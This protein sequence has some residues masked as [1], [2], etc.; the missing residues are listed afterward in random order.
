MKNIND[1]INYLAEKKIIIMCGHY[2]AGKTNLSVNF[3]VKLKEQTGF[4]Y[5]LADLDMVNP[6][7]RGAD[8]IGDLREHGI[9]III[10]QFANTNLEVS[11]VPRE[12]HSVFD[13]KE[14]RAIIDIGGDD[15]GAVILGVLTDKIQRENYELIY[16]INK[17][18]NLTK[19]VGTAVNLAKAIEHKSKLKITAV[20]NNSNV[21]SMTT[22]KEILDSLEYAREI[23]DLLN[24]PLLGTSS[25]IEN[26]LD[27]SGE[28]VYNIFGIKNYTKRLF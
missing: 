5:T 26:G 10:P 25:M 1:I 4:V 19:D 20:I 12:I 14:K 21:G 16:V 24:V 11:T 15:N 28:T 6:Y 22:P 17:Y 18:R 2:G 9:D 7:F 27:F 13:I 23:S 3:S 8:N